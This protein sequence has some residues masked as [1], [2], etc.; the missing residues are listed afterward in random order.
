M[1]GIQAAAGPA[2][3]G[4]QEPK[5]G[6]RKA[7]PMEVTS[8][9]GR[10]PEPQPDNRH[11]SRPW[12]CP[13]EDTTPSLMSPQPPRAGGAQLQGSSVLE[14]KVR[15]LKEKMTAGK[16]GASPCPTS[17]E[18][19]FPKKPKCIRVP[20]G[21]PRTPSEGTFMPDAVVVPPAQDL[22]DGQLT[23]SD[24]EEAPMRNGSLRPPRLPAPGCECWNTLPEAMWTLPNQ[25][26]GLLTEPS[27]LQES[28]IREVT[29]CQ[30]GSP[31]PGNKIISTPSMRRGSS[32]LLQDGVVTG[33]DLDSTSLTS[34][35]D[36]VP[37]T[38]LLGNLWR[39]GD[40]GPL[41]TGGSTLSLSER[42]ER[43][44]LLLQKIL[45]VSRCGPSKAGAPAWTPSCGRAAAERTAGDVEWDWGDSLQDSDQ[46]RT[47]GPKPEPVLSPRHEEA[48]H[49]LQRARMKARTRPL[50]ASHDIVPTT[51]L[52]SRD[53][54]R[55]PAPAP[56]VPAACR[57]SL[58]NG[59]VSDSSSGESSGGQRPRRGPSPSHVRFEDESARE[60]EF[61]YLERLQQRQRHVLGTVLQAADQ[62]PLRSKPDLAD[63]INGGLRLW[64]PAEEALHRLER[65]LDTGGSDRKCC[66][67]GDCMEDRHPAQ[68]K[69]A[70]DPRVLQELE[71]VLV[72][73]LGSCGL[74]S[75][76]RLLPAE[77]GL[78][79]QWI[80]E[81]HIGN[82]A[83]PEETNPALDYT[84][85]ANSCRANSEEARTSQ[86]S[87]PCGQ[88]QGSSP[89]LPGSRPRAG[90]RWSRTPEMELPWGPQAQCHLSGVDGVEVGDEVK[91]SRGH[92]PR[93]TLFLR[94]DALR[95]PP[96]LA[97]K[98]TLLGSQWQPGAGLGDH[99]APPAESRAPSRTA[100][101]MTSSMK[102][103]P[104][105]PGSQ[106]R[107]ME[108]HK[109][110]EIAST[111]S[112][113][114]SNAEPCAPNTQQPAASLFSQG[115]V[116]TPPPSR[117]TTSPLSHRKVALA[118]SRR[119]GDQGEPVNPSRSGVLRT[120][121][122]TPAQAQSC[123]PGVRHP[124]QGLSTNNC[125]NSV[126]WGPQ[127]PSDGA[128]HEDRVEHALYS[129]ELGLPQENSRDGGPQG[130]PGSADVATINSTSITLS[131][132]SEEPESSQEADGALL[133]T[134]SGS[135]ECVPPRALPG[136]STGSGSPL[137]VPSDKNKKRSNS[138]VSTLGL[139]KFFS[140][141]GQSPRP[142]L[143]KARSY[144]VEQL[145][146]TAPGPASHA[147]A[148]S[149][150]SL[151][152]VSPSHQRRKAASFQNLHSLLSG[153]GDRSSL[154]VVGGPGDHGAAGRVAKAPPRRALS[155]EDVGAPSLARTVGRVVE[156][157]PDGTSQ[158]QLQRSPEG[159]FGFCVASGNGRRD[160]GIYVQE[161]A[162]VS[163]AKLYSGLLGVGDEILEVN[164]AKVAGLG[165]VHIKELL[166]HS[167]SLFVRV[168]RQRPAPR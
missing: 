168:L 68:G 121:G 136:A 128:V 18:Q 158:L 1:E 49:L 76:L 44:R 103:G 134:E 82:T 148:P 54:Q 98:P 91:K 21:G 40:L 59:N 132:F 57:D 67:C 11:L 116:P 60:A 127:E 93:G 24:N 164:G 153:K 94:E 45:S 104:S 152:L 147:R 97:S 143:G 122:Q 63:Y 123:S 36:F 163:T 71:G 6:N 47:F 52:G 124:L 25:E 29:P 38:A 125:N 114:H 77:P 81:T 39:G 151:H 19:S 23:S 146:P 37:R 149:L 61:R 107:V 117:K 7:N 109:S 157:F 85:T 62:G 84:D 139:K 86:A 154:Y 79:S 35:E 88:T 50:R 162:D 100:H 12:T 160:S 5:T 30:P 141:L 145:H 140:T 42:V 115:W 90:H 89:G 101:A 3:G 17:Y 156:V 111:S 41:S 13:W 65:S 110:V 56:R 135:R 69:A 75:P 83:V 129:Q 2:S 150:Q 55:S 43:S 87:R 64:D 95:K 73:P 14:S 46:N 74:C 28:P 106:A 137:A 138:I 130:F 58:Q 112:L 33:G 22:T 16:Q 99:W 131:L 26:S 72:E 10:S 119:L 108:G 126:P 9:V 144:S 27:S 118:G 166:A 92:A 15:A 31:G 8:A 161:M 96:A 80:R 51:A 48:K 155:V 105:G 66:T 102:L 4:P 120:C 78:P 70:P 159:T 167:E 165:L 113:Q 53:G 133:S 20:A 142:K 34:E 32:Y